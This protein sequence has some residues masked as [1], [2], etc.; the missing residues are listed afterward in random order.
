ME[1]TLYYKNI[2]MKEEGDNSFLD[3]SNEYAKS[4]PK[5]PYKRICNTTDIKIGEAEFEATENPGVW[6]KSTY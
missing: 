6:Y 4:I 1:I 3:N 5:E 2:N